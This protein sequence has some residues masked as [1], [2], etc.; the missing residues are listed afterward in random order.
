MSLEMKPIVIMCLAVALN[1]CNTINPPGPSSS[2]QEAITPVAGEQTSGGKVYLES[3][4][5]KRMETITLTARGYGAP[6]KNYYPEAN[7]RLMAM[8][9]A[10]LDAYRALAERINGL[11]IWGGTTIGEM[12]L[13]EDRF[14]VVIDAFVVGA[15]V[16]SVMPGKD[17]VY[18]AIV[19]AEVDQDFLAK[20]LAH[21]KDTLIVPPESVAMTHAIRKD[22][23]AAAKPAEKRRANSQSNFYFSD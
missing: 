18:E 13:E 5:R 17:G 6:P 11:R 10:K 4:E 14:K 21:R 3:E 2:Q 1:A 12:V 20:A 15:K 16:V 19:E 7:R 9:A 23:S 8:R 22:E